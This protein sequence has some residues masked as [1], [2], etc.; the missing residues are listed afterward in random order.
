MYS[1]KSK[2]IKIIVCIYD[3]PSNSAGHKGLPDFGHGALPV[4]IPVALVR[5]VE[6]VLREDGVLVTGVPVPVTIGGS[7]VLVTWFILTN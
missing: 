5:G 1:I 7:E 4:G 2:F 6:G 3:S